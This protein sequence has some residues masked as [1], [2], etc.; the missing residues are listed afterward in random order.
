[1]TNTKRGW[2]LVVKRGENP[3]IWMNPYGFF[4]THAD[5]K[6]EGI[7][8]WKNIYKIVRARLTWGDGK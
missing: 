4:L 1:M 3:N 8:G 5:A 7:D 6:R 2:T